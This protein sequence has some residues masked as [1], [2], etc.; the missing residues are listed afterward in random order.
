MKNLDLLIVG[1]LAATVAYF[2]F[3]DKNTL[4]DL[5]SNLGGGGGTGGYSTES[6]SGAAAVAAPIAAMQSI[7][8][9]KAT[10]KTGSPLYTYQTNVLITP[11]GQPAKYA[12]VLA[13]NQPQAI[14]IAKG[15]Q[16]EQFKVFKQDILTAGGKIHPKGL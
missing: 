10:G 9:Y 2:L 11:K 15:I 4:N 8:T 16:Y 13:Y 1:G 14:N 3:K 12:T 5:F 7:T 6:G